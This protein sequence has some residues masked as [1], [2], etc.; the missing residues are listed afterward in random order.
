MTV[1]VKRNINE[2]VNKNLPAPLNLSFSSICG[3]HNNFSGVKS[4]LLKCSPDI[5]APCK[6]NLNSSI[7]TNELSVAGYLFL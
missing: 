6:I 3:I 2:L 4:F 1:T 5:L 7:T